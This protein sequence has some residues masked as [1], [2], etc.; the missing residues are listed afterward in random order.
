MMVRQE[1]LVSLLCSVCGPSLGPFSRMTTGN[2]RT[3]L[4]KSG[5]LAGFWIAC[6]LALGENSQ[7]SCNVQGTGTVRFLSME[8]GF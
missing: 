7:T 2:E 5:L 4:T 8:G 1:A 3:V 6:I